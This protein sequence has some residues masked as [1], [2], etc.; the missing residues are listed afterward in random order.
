MTGRAATLMRVAVD[1]TTD[2]PTIG[3]PEPALELKP[4]LYP[5][6]EYDIDP[7]G[8]RILVLW[9]EDTGDA[10]SSARIHLVMNWFEE[11]D[12]L[13]SSDGGRP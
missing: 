12:R 8:E 4:S 9:F 7:S 11:L 5:D 1:L 3:A 13:L 6:H 10:D 2:P